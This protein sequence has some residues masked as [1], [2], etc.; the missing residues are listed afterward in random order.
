MAG[1]NMNLHPLL[2]KGGDKRKFRW[3]FTITPFIGDQVSMLPPSKGARPNLSFKEYSAEHLNETIYFPGKV[4]WS[5]LELSL[6]DVK[7]S[8]NPIFEWMRKIYD[9]DPTVGFYGPSLLPPAQIGAPHFKRQA[10]LT[11]YDGC[12]RIIEAWIYMNA[13]PQKIDWTDLDMTNSE[14][15]SVDLSLRYDRAYLVSPAKFNTL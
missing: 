5:T 4:E 8:D 1:R 11:L 10:I 2:A 13:F 9:P 6:Y 3:L 15:T 7:C 12:G 14:L